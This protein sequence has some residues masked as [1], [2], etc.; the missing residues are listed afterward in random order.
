MATFV[1]CFMHS[2]N[3]KMEEQAHEWK[4]P[5]AKQSMNKLV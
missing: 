2:Q 3:R 5:G 4:S 1:C